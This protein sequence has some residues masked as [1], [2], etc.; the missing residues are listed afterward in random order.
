MGKTPTQPFV[1]HALV[2]GLGNTL[3]QAAGMLLLPLYTRFLRPAEYGD[4]EV[5]TR[6][7]EF[8]AVCL[9]FNGIRQAV[10]MLHGQNEAAEARRGVAATTVAVLAG[11]VTAGALLAVVASGRLGRGLGVEDGGLLALGVLTAVVDSSFAV[12]LAL[13]QARTQSVFFVAATLAHFIGRVGLCVL[14][15]AGLGWGA[16]GV[17]LASL[18]ASGACTVVLAARELCGGGVRVRLAGVRE[19]VG[20]A[21]PLLLCGLGFCLLNYGDRFFLLHWGGEHEVGIYAF[22]YKLALAVSMF[23]RAPLAMVWGPS[24]Y[25]LAKAADAPEVFG[26]AYARML[27]AYVF[28][29][30]GL[31]LLLDEAI[32]VAGGPAYAAAGAIVPV[33]VLAYFFLAAAD[34]M[35]GAFYLRRRSDLKTWVALAS[36]ALML[37]LYVLLIPSWGAA[38]AA[39]A[40]VGGLAGHALL[41]RWV[42]QR[43][44]VVRHESG[45]VVAMLALAVGLWL[46]SRL[47]PAAAWAVPVKVGL[48]LAWPV[49]L[50][51]SGLVRPEEKAWA[52]AGWA[53]AVSRF[54]GARQPEGVSPRV[55]SD[56]R[57]QMAD[58]Q[59]QPRPGNLPSEIAN[60]KS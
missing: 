25:R 51:R 54:R 41:T 14:L 7:G 1:R 45:R 18:V 33:V 13:S 59:A 43:L 50:W 6:L 26:R 32:A 19:M 56:F 29:G 3:L 40:T 44:F 2:Y 36:T 58:L 42:S 39:W 55:I 23:T 17:L 11:C 49:A 38:G 21:L 9:L 28:V 22:G 46:V 37:L 10:L 31:C 4:L 8:V 52:R 27:A 35:D 34:M 30:L 47:L 48:W 20:F 12:L 5:V 16:H 15:V 57:F 60:L 53:A 24:T